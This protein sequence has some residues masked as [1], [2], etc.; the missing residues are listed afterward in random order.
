MHEFLVLGE[1]LF[2]RLNIV[3]IEMPPLRERKEDIPLLLDFFLKKYNETALQGD[4]NRTNVFIVDAA[5]PPDHKFS[6]KIR[7]NV[8]LACFVG[9]FL[10][11][12]L[13]FIF[14]YLDDTIKS[15]EAVERLFGIT[16]LGTINTARE[17]QRIH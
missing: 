2:Y 17:L 8:A 13:V 10:G 6:P 15:E 4:I 9:L 3:Q 5:V 7:L 14:D 16:I 1:D 12:G 11:V